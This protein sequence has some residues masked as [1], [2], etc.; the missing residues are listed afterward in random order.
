MLRN[1]CRTL[2]L[3]RYIICW[4]GYLCKVRQ[5]S[6]KE[7]TKIKTQDIHYHV[8]QHGQ[9]KKCKNYAGSFEVFTKHLVHKRWSNFLNWHSNFCSN[10]SQ[11]EIHFSIIFRM[12]SI[13]L[14]VFAPL[15]YILIHRICSDDKT[16]LEHLI[17][18][19][20]V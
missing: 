13:F 14:D 1:E 19:V 2:L 8:R 20:R 11:C 16:L 15:L 7:I 10:I 18:L 6:Y 5:K 4:S 9:W 17:S 3:I 12:L